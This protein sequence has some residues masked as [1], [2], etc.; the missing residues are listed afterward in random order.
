MKNE[1]SEQESSIVKAYNAIVYL[2]HWHECPSQYSGRNVH[3]QICPRDQ[4]HC[5]YE[6]HG[7]QTTMM[8]LNYMICLHTNQDG[9]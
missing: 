3:G 2:G 8:T 9:F 4:S 5:N 7:R 1:T 6:S